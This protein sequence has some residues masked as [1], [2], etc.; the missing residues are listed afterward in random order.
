MPSQRTEVA[1]ARILFV[2]PDYHCGVVESAGK[3]L[4]CGFV[5]MAQ[6]LV[7]DGHRVRINDAMTSF[8]NSFY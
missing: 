2:T 5:Y 3:W 1:M 8:L 6:G 4:N 7:E